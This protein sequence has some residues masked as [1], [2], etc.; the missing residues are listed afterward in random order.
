MAGAVHESRVNGGLPQEDKGGQV[1]RSSL[2]V[3]S[4]NEANGLASVV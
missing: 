4:A 3:S 1:P 2:R